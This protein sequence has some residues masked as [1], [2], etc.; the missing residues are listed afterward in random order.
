MKVAHK[1]STFLGIHKISQEFQRLK[2]WLLSGSPIEKS[3]YTAGKI[4]NSEGLSSLPLKEITAI[5]TI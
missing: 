1:V 3:A 5:A 2:S 4:R